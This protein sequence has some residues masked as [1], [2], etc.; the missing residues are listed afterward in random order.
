M[1]VGAEI[2]KR[3]AQRVI[4]FIKL[5]DE[6]PELYHVDIFAPLPDGYI[7]AIASG[8]SRLEVQLLDDIVTAWRGE[9]IGVFDLTEMNHIEH[10]P[11]FLGGRRINGSPIFGERNHGEWINLFV[12]GNAMNKME[13]IFLSGN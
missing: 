6:I 9:P 12:A 2:K 5:L 7:I 1:R 4:E 8:W 3:Q 10:D 11:D 13:Q